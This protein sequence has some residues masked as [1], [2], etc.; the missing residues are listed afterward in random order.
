LIHL[1]AVD[2]SKLE[3]FSELPVYKADAYRIPIDRG[4]VKQAP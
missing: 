4:L 2:F 1:E 3:F